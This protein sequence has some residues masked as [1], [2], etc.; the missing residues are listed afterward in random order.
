MMTC[1]KSCVCEAGLLF[2]LTICDA[3]KQHVKIPDFLCAGTQ[4]LLSSSAVEVTRAGVW[5]FSEKWGIGEL[6]GCFL[7]EVGM[8]VM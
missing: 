3:R 1:Q 6:G 5:V 7:V 4:H 8:V 2:S